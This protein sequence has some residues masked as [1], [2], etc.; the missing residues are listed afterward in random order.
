MLAGGAALAWLVF[1]KKTAFDK[2]RFTVENIVPDIATKSVRLNVRIVN[3]TLETLDI[4]AIAGGLS[5]GTIYIGKVVSTLPNS[6]Q[7]GDS[8]VIP[9]N[10]TVTGTDIINLISQYVS[11]RASGPVVF[12]FDGQVDVSGII[13]PLRMEYPIVW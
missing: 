11:N 9:V 4:R 13:V 3:P 6:V 8:I 5:V 2:L 12:N 10:F 7:P 1:R